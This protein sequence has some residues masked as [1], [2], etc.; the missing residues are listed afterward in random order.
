ML[1][2][3]RRPPMD[4]AGLASN[5]RVRR[6]VPATRDQL[7]RPHKTASPLAI[8]FPWHSRRQRRRRMLKR[9]PSPPRAILPLLPRVPVPVRRG[10]RAAVG[11]RARNMTTQRRRAILSLKH[12][13]Q[14]PRRAT[15]AAQVAREIR[16]PVRHL[17]PADTVPATRICQRPMLAREIL[18]PTKSWI[19]LRGIRRGMDASKTT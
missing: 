17:P 1:H 10:L 14:Q 19:P 6:K 2:P 11:N 12:S 8:R 15:R 7:L 18:A 16:K 4:R 3:T 13:R 5:R 9:T